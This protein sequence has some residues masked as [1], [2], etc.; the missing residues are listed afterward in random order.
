MAEKGAVPSSSSKVGENL[1]TAFALHLP[2]VRGSNSLV[3][4]LVEQSM[5]CIF[6]WKSFSQHAAHGDRSI[7]SWQ[8][9]FRNLRA[10]FFSMLPFNLDSPGWSSALSWRRLQ[11][12]SSTSCLSWAKRATSSACFASSRG[13]ARAAAREALC[14]ALSRVALWWALVRVALC[15]ALSRVAL[16]MGLLVP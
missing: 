15:L 5:F 8:V 1:K 11:G 14:W 6:L 7:A 16:L 9:L 4:M 13:T 10:H 2:P 12:N 3:G